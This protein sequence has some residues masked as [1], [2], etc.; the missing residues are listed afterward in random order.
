MHSQR[1]RRA[2][3]ILGSGLR[4]RAAAAGASGLQAAP[5]SP[6]K[7]VPAAPPRWRRQWRTPPRWLGAPP[8]C[9]AQRTPPPAACSMRLSRRVRRSGLAERTTAVRAGGSPTGLHVHVL[10]VR[11][12]SLHH[13]RDG[14]C[15]GKHSLHLIALSRQRPD[16]G[17]H[18]LGHRSALLVGAG[19]RHQR[20]RGRYDSDPDF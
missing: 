5:K 18:R 8:D 20:L 4:S 7:C 14:I 17:A 2:R 9:A 6:Q 15:I 11:V 1:L 12:H 13:S 3:G 16:S 19:S 10:R